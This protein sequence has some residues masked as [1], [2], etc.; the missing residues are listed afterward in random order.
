MKKNFFQRMLLKLIGLAF[1]LAAFACN[2]STEGE[3]QKPNVV[4]VFI[5]D[6]GFADFKPFGETRYPTPNVSE[7]AEEGR[8]YYNFYVPVAVS[9]ASRAAL[10]SG[11][12]PG[13][14]GVFGAH[15]PNS[16]CLDPEFATLGEV[17]Q[18]NG[19]TTAS[20][21]KWHLGDV[22]GQR[23]HSRGF[24]ESCG[25]MYS[26]DMWPYHPENPEHWGQWPLPYWENGEV[27]IDSM[28]PKDQRNLSTWY[29]ENAVDF[30]NRHDD[31]PF[32]LYVP[33]SMPH[34]P[35]FV[36]DKFK[37]ESGLGLYEDV[38]MELDWSVGEIMDAL[39]KNGV[40]E[41]TMFI[42]IGSDNGPWLSY[43]DRAGKTPYREGKGTTFDGGVRNSCIIRYP[44]HIEPNT[45]SHNAFASIDILPTIC[46]V[47]G[48]PLPDNEIDGKNVWDLITHKPGA[49]NPHDYYPFAR[50]SSLEA[51]ISADG[52]WKLHLP[53][54][55]RSL[56]KG[57]GG[58]YTR[59]GVR[60]L[61]PDSNLGEQI[62]RPLTYTQRKIDTALFDM[63]HDP[64]EKR[65]VFHRYPEITDRLMEY[66]EQ[67]NER[68]YE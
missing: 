19:Y 49:E 2:Q 5:D 55:Y 39:E 34:V 42:F 63:V 67:H 14:T 18:Q 38:M 52:H 27:K 35:L 8:S 57:E 64:Y 45:V 47:T 13:R 43:M 68:F 36:S 44:E 65:N 32:F 29:T 6:A 59:R 51:V 50:H 66:A 62:R 48:S 60:G 10:L 24:D 31:E 33:H 25:L 12:Y 9:S 23:P 56:E 17:M 58:T 28:T 20:F 40:E 22:P 1:V 3:Q 4:M 7:L 53:H 37:G 26:N 21:G 61:Q 46:H 30:I 16:E 15:G 11:C 54:Q 41:N